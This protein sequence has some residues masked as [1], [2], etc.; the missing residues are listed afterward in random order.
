MTNP[1]SVVDLVLLLDPGAV[2]SRCRRLN[3]GVDVSVFVSTRPGLFRN[4]DGEKGKPLIGLF[5]GVHDCGEGLGGVSMMLDTGALGC[6]APL[7]LSADTDFRLGDE[8]S[9]NTLL[10]P[11]ELSLLCRLFFIVRLSI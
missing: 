9:L 8:E 7:S 5:L 4:W 2:V 10:F 6:G 11:P 1:A 3:T